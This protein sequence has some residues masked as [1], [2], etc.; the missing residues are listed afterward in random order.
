MAIKCARTRKFLAQVK[1]NREM[2]TIRARWDHADLATLTQAEIQS[3]MTKL[4][5]AYMNILGYYPT[6]MRPPY[7]STNALA[8]ST[9]T[10]L[11]YKII[12][13]DIDT[14]DWAEDPIGGVDLSI[15]WYEGN[16]TLGGTISLNHDP[17]QPTAET[18]LPAILTYLA[19]KNL[20]C[21]FHMS[22]LPLKRN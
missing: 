1:T 2:L 10:T 18:F 19:S 15:A 16:Q 17:Y 21:K 6:Y 13:C 7:L 11:G 12:Q 22:N 5:T 14:Q 8:I 9:L 4:E 20:K 3:E